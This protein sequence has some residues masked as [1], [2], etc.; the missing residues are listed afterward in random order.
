MKSGRCMSTSGPYHRTDA[1]RPEE[2]TVHLLM[3]VLVADQRAADL[4]R[5]AERSRRARDAAHRGDRAFGF[6]PR[7]EEVPRKP[8]FG[9]DL[10]ATQ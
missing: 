7:R 3:T 1:D 4:R 5:S 8:T 10:E 2:E 9:I 6:H